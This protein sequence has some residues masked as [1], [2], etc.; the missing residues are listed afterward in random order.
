M[1]DAQGSQECEYRHSGFT[2]DQD[3]PSPE[4]S[5]DKNRKEGRNSIGSSDHIASVLWA[6][7]EFAI[8]ILLDPLQESHRIL[9]QSVD[10][11]ELV[12]A[13]EE[14]ADPGGASVLGIE[15]DLFECQVT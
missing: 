9:V 7:R 1:L 5:H 10:A 15:Q 12:E 2:S 6:D 13:V 14:E 3:W 4:I 11:R 8:L